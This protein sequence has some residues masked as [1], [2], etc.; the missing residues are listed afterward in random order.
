MESKQ[1]SKYIW[2]RAE[3]GV[4]RSVV[5]YDR[6]GNKLTRHL[7]PD[8]TDPPRGSK[9]WRHQNP[10]NITS[11]GPFA[12]DHGSIGSA[13][14]P[15]ARDPKKIDCFAIFP[16]YEVGR[17]AFAALLKT[18]AYV[19]LTLHEFPRHYTGILSPDTPDTEEVK[20][21]RKNLREISGFDMQR[22]IRTCNDRE[23]EKLLDSI[24]RC[25]GWFPGDE[26]LDEVSKIVGVKFVQKTAAEFLIED[27]S[28]IR[29]WFTKARAISLANTKR[30]F[31]V[32]VHGHHGVYLRP[33]PHHLR[34]RDLVVKIE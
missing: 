25:E 32:V 20:I 11:A 2:V 29:E 1:F 10:G 8:A 12:R 5:Y 16:T 15:N 23:Y 9:S 22:T 31:V 30:L 27:P 6:D 13:G 19:D 7:D 28:G 33:F 21:Y 4:K 14:Y 18:K 34:F 26:T 17:Q 3:G 24:Q